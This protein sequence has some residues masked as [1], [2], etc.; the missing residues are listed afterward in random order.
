MQSALMRKELPIEPVLVMPCQSAGIGAMP[1]VVGHLDALSVKGIVV[2][3][4]VELFLDPAA[5]LEAK[6]RC[7]GDVACIKQTV[8]IS[9][10]EEAIASL[11]HAAVGIGP[12]MCSLERWQG[13][14]LRYRAT[15]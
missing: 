12:N 9:P 8:D 13:L 7:D 10:Q 2:N 11:V 4:V 5:D 3:A 6:F 1:R 15:R 14:L